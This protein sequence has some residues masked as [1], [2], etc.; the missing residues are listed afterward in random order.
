M[1]SSDIEALD[2][3]LA[4][5]LVFTNHLGQLLGKGD[6]LAAYRSGVLK[7]ARL[8]PSERQVQVLNDAAVVSVR[9]QISGTHRDSPTDGDSRYMRVWVHSQQQGW[10][11]VAA[12]SV[13]VT[14]LP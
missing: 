4:P 6:D 14:H 9:M 13:L 3:L 12:L 8:E 5:D 2:E 7:I 10:R 11:I 1:L